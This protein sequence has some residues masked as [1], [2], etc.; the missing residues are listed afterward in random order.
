VG[1]AE[2]QN[3][4]IV[5][6]QSLHFHTR[7]GV[8]EPLELVIPGDSPPHGHAVVAVEELLPEEL[9]PGHGVPLPAHQPRREHVYVVQVEEDLVEDAVGEEGADARIHR[10]ILPPRLEANGVEGG[11]ARPPAAPHRQPPHGTS[12]P[13]RLRCP[14]LPRAALPSSPPRTS[15]PAFTGCSGHP[16]RWWSPPLPITAPLMCRRPDSSSPEL[17]TAP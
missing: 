9:V 11:E 14:R 12:A 17:P 7:D 15:A 2:V 16:S 13:R 4:V 3:L 8:V 5:L 10:I 1:E 6:L